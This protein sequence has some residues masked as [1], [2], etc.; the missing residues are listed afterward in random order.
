[1]SVVCRPDSLTRRLGFAN[2]PL[3]G[4]PFVSASDAIARPKRQA[5]ARFRRWLRT[6]TGTSAL[7]W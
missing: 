6:R 1:L 2:S 4:R 5:A 3:V 7:L